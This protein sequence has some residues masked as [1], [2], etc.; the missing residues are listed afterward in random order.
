M[1][2][3]M[4]ENITIAE[5]GMVDHQHQEP[6]GRRSSIK[7]SHRLSIDSIDDPDPDAECRCKIDLCHV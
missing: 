7:V 1:G 5:N 6:S 3:A 4:E 2:S